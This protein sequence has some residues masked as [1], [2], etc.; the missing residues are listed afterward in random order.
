MAAEEEAGWADLG[1]IIIFNFLYYCLFLENINHFWLPESIVPTVFFF[2]H[3]LQTPDVNY[4][5][6]P[7]GHC[8]FCHLFLCSMM[9]IFQLVNSLYF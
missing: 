8:N 7:S 6:T 4:R 5:I 3:I 2:K 9:L 1:C